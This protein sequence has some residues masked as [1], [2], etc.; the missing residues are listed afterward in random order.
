[1]LCGLSVMRC[2]P[3]RL[4]IDIETYCD[5]DIK[6]VGG[7]KYA[8]NCE[9]LLFA[10]A[11][12]DE[13]VQIVDLTAGETLPNDVLTALTD[14]TITKCAYNAQFE[15]T[16]L[17]HYLHRLRPEKPF[18]YLDP[19]GWSCTMV[20]SLMLGLPG[21]LEKVSKVLKLS[22]DKAKMSVGKQ[23]ITY[24]CKP[25]KPTKT[26]GGRTRNLPEHAP[27]KWAAFKEYCVRDVVAERTIRERLINYP[28]IGRAH[29]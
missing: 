24:F 25:C 10:Y 20:H 28:E 11:W 17:S 12:N 13:P 16:V 14:N 1:M 18:Q 19:L 6:K 5:L 9:V 27:E 23:L 21:S 3:M 4:S 22:E 29:V 15:R 7:Y 8:E 2:T 26:N